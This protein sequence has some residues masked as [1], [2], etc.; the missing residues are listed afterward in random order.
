MVAGLVSSAWGALVGIAV[1]PLYLRYLGVEAYGL[2]G[3][4]VT[5]QALLQLLDMGIAPTVN[6]EMARSAAKR[7]VLEMRSML[8]TLALV[9]WSVAALIFAVMYMIAPQIGD[10]W[11]HSQTISHE[12]ITHAVVLMGLVIACRWPIGLYQ[13]ALVGL[14]QISLS[15]ALNMAMTTLGSFGGVCIL[16]FVSPTV[17]A[18]FLW[19]AGVGLLYAGILRWYAW[20]RVG[21]SRGAKCELAAL[22]SIW[23]FSATMMALTFSGLVFSQMDK[24]IL[25]K[26][27]TLTGFA[28]YM[29]AGVVA[30]AL[31]ILIT[32]FY[33]AIYPRFCGYVEVDTPAP[34]LDLFRISSRLL[35]T[36]L[37][38]TAMII[39]IAGEDLISLWTGNAALAREVGPLA[40]LIA[41]GT[42]IHGTMYIP[43][44]LQLAKGMTF[45]PLTI[46]IILLVIMVPVT[47]SLAF[48]YGALGGAAAWL[49]LHVLYVILATG[50]MQKFVG[51]ST[52]VGWLFR[53]VGIPL[54]V[55]CLVGALT[56]YFLDSMDSNSLVKLLVTGG[57]A[58][59]AVAIIFLV[60]PYM[61]LSLVTTMRAEL[62]G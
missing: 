47:T 31:N 54:V 30:S 18:L 15:S 56:K 44:A 13:S 53:E 49:L 51:N 12:S 16:A 61:R 20:Q 8:K 42:A 57:S 37:F 19:Q 59:S 40:A 22:R 11:L 52:G 26:L 28:H 46:N 4:L 25:S 58:A 62:R 36:V 60:S 21:G 1:V 27:L 41:A 43:H 32:P 45:I 33:N 38:S 48:R 17:E 39:V 23:R 34:L 6:R 2:I 14:Q 10:R 29:L 3:F 24:V 5:T 50:L 35:A 9:Y 7:N 55:C